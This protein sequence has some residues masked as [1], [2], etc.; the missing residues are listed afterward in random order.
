M[1]CDLDQ[2]LDEGEADGAV[3]ARD[4][5]DLLGSRARQVDRPPA[6]ERAAIVDPHH[7]RAA[8][9]RVGHADFAAERQA[10]GARRSARAG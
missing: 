4:Q 5:A 6:G 1:G 9:G 2:A 7:H 8:V 3:A 10:C